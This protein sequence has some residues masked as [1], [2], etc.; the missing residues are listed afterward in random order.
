MKKMKKINNYKP[1]PSIPPLLST[2]LSTLLSTFSITLILILSLLSLV[3]TLPL[4][5]CLHI[6]AT[7]IKDE[8]EEYKENLSEIIKDMMLKTLL[9]Q[10]A[11]T[12]IEQLWIEHTLTFTEVLTEIQK[13]DERF[14][15]IVNANDIEYKITELP[16]APKDYKD[17]HNKLIETYSILEDY[18]F[19]I[20]NPTARANNSVEYGILITN[21]SDE[22]LNALSELAE[23]FDETFNSN[24]NFETP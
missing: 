24:E 2:F 3:F 11:A 13:E 18:V 8:K 12:Q 21:I 5:G 7:E 17:I 20:N 22:W 16:D 4:I 1:K 23:S 10:H 9:L 6:E 19:L 14:S 15:N